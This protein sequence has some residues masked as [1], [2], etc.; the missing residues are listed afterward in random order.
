MAIVVD[1]SLTIRTL[2]PS[3]SSA[4]AWFSDPDRA[5][6]RIMAPDLWVSETVSAVR[7]MVFARQLTPSEGVRA[8]DALFALGIETVPLT[9]SLCRSA[10]EW[11]AR[12][13]QARAYDSIYLALAEHL[14][15]E[16]WTADRRL[17]NRAQQ[18]GATWVHLAE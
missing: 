4:H 10:L 3:T 11:A 6:A 15:A 5:T 17:A 7:R 14:H 9:I 2:R 12:L 16:F 1:A 18:C 8:L 13:G